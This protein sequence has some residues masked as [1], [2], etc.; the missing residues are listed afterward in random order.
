[1]NRLT[2]ADHKTMAAAVRKLCITSDIVR[3]ERLALQYCTI[4]QNHTSDYY[5][6]LQL[7]LMVTRKSCYSLQPSIWRKKKAAVSLKP[8][9]SSQTEVILSY[10]ER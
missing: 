10:R 6:V 8:M 7:L 3:I 5:S 4:K 1:M 9:M 2:F